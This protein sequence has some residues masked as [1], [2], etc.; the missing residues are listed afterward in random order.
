MPSAPGRQG[1]RRAKTAFLALAGIL[2]LVVAAGSGLAIATIHHVEASIIKLETGENALD[3]IRSGGA[4]A[5]DV[6]P[7]VDPVC[8]RDACTFLILGSD[9]RQGLD[10]SF[11]STKN[12][13]G[14]R[15]DTIIVVQV[16]QQL[17]RTVVLSI[18][19]DLLVNIPGHGTGK[20][21]TALE[22][23]N[24][25]IVQAVEKLTG[26]Q[27]NHFVRINFAGFQSLVDALG[28]VTVCTDRPLVDLLSHLNLAKPGCHNLRGG[29]ALAFVRARH[30]E[31]DLIPDFSRI[32][33]QQQFMRAVIQKVLSLG[34]LFQLPKLVGAVQHNLVM[35]D[36]LDLYN[37]QD[38]SLKLAAKGQKGV[39]FRVVPAVPVQIDGVDYVQLVQ[40]DASR[41]FDHMRTGARLGEVGKRAYGTP[42]S[43][44]N[45]TVQ[46]LDAGN[47]SAAATVAQ[48]LQ[49]AGFLVLPAKAA[50]STLTTS[51]ILWG[52]DVQRDDVA[53]GD[54]VATLASYLP[55]LSVTFDSV[56]TH[57]QTPIV[58]VG[59]DFPGIDA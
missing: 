46:I 16:D 52:P 49:Q 51:A 37:L 23:G 44:A 27:I 22:F 7:S 29:Q 17:D 2:S 20:I 14:Q 25:V 8:P 42:V 3:L 9:S 54:P 39:F 15:S 6:L 56:N 11:G 48:F 26:L 58:V 24:D 30:I 18:P 21:N 31:G 55:K 57:E 45:V 38:L 43:P 47:P 19:R 36:G 59:P 35:D 13:P 5:K 34:S 12:S 10:R 53:G 41:L 1:R 4:G 28:G 50:P 40:P 33:R 32:A